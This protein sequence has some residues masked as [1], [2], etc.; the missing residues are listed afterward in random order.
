MSRMLIIVA[1]LLAL[2]TVAV[3]TRPPVVVPSSSAPV[4][5]NMLTWLDPSAPDAFVMAN[6]GIRIRQWTDQSPRKKHFVQPNPQKQPMLV[7]LDGRARRD[8]EPCVEN[9]GP[10]F[11]NGTGMVGSG[12]TIGSSPYR[13][14]STGSVSTAHIFIVSRGSSDADAFILESLLKVSAPNGRT[15]LD[16][17]HMEFAGGLGNAFAVSINAVANAATAVSSGNAA[18]PLDVW[19]ITITPQMGWA[20]RITIYKNNAFLSTSMLLG[21]PPYGV[22]K[23]VLANTFNGVVGEL[24][25]YSDMTNDERSATTLFLCDKHSIAC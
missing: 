20:T 2:A 5:D 19:T 13:R 6:D 4:T 25:V 14:R 21:T 23:A 16:I 24:M 11:G 10:S 7:T 1:G 12:G 18:N 15:F 22:S 3:S 17:G 9:C 8:D